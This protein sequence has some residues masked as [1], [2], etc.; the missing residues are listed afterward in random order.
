MK[1]LIL[2]LAVLYFVLA[3]TTPTVYAGS[4]G[5]VPAHPNPKDSSSF[6][7]LELKLKQGAAVKKDFAIAN[8]TNQTL[9]LVLSTDAPKLIFFTENT[10]TVD[11]NKRKRVDILV[12]IPDNYQ[13]GDYLFNI[14]A[15]DIEQTQ[16]KESLAVK[17]KIGSPKAPNL[18][19]SNISI[20]QD[21]EKV[22]VSG[23]IT[24]N[25]SSTVE[26]YGLKLLLDNRTPIIKSLVQPYEYYWGEEQ[27]VNPGEV[28]GISHT[29]VNK[30]A[31][32]DYIASID[33]NYA[34]NIVRK[35]AGTL[36]V[37]RLSDTITYLLVFGLHLVAVLFAIFI[38][39]R[40]QLIKRTKRKILGVEI[41]KYSLNGPEV[42]KLLVEIRNIIRQEL[43]TLR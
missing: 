39:V 22:T 26:S 4:F 9:E 12:K 18:K 37:L 1:K 42:D 25:S 17:I 38:F 13:E 43:K 3:G 41:P 16:E 34:D 33:L 23:V 32:G 14:F 19:L 36:R 35:K 5:I 30:L 15:S 7:H 2:H 20:D 28:K 6:T 11:P 21:G 31:P 24:N 40:G 27:T 8:L 10:I 29:I